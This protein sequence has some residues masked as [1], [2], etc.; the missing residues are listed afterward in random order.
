MSNEIQRVGANL[1]ADGLSLLGVP[2]TTAA[3]LWARFV[4]RKTDEARDILFQEMAKGS[5]DPLLA[6]SEDDALAIIYRYANA[7]R[8]HSARRNLKL[9]GEVSGWRTRFEGLF[10]W[11][12][13]RRSLMTSFGQR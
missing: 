4:Q 8:Q 3:D 12:T 1:F 9:L 2:T 11:P 6:A 5:K 13:G 10:P 7:I